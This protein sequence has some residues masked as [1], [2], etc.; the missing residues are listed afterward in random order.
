MLD[1]K[2]YERWSRFRA[3]RYRCRM[4]TRTSC[5]ALASQEHVARAAAGHTHDFLR[6]RGRL[7]SVHVEQLHSPRTHCGDAQ[8]ARVDMRQGAHLE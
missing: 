2:N 7:V 8:D 1:I 6:H 3:Q 4:L 5:I